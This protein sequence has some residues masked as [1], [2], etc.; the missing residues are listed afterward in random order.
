MGAVRIEEGG[1]VDANPN[2]VILDGSDAEDRQESKRC[3]IPHH[4]GCGM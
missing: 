2:I 1:M 3:H 4:K